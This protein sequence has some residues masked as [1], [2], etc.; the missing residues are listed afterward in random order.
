MP[1]RLRLLI[2]DHATQES[3]D[4]QRDNEFVHGARV[5]PGSNGLNKGMLSLTSIELNPLRITIL[6]FVRLFWREE[7]KEGGSGL[8]LLFGIDLNVDNCNR[9][10]N[11]SREENEL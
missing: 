8:K 2:Y 7:R 5:F 4:R 6:E 10:R 1:K 3:L 11:P 9:N